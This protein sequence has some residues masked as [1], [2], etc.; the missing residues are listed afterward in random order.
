MMAHLEGKEDT[1]DP[2]DQDSPTKEESE[3]DRRLEWM[4]DK[5]IAGNAIG[6]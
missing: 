6:Q 4:G 5:D 1:E 3:S 2:T